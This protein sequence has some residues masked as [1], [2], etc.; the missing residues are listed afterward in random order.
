[1]A[2]TRPATSTRRRTTSDT[3]RACSR[4]ARSS[5]P[6][7]PE[8]TTARTLTSVE[9]VQA[10]LAEQRYLADRALSTAVFLAAELEQPLLLEGE[11]GVGKTEGA[12]ALAGATGS[13]PIRPQCHQ[14]VGLHPPGYD[15]GYG[16]QP[17]APPAARAGARGRR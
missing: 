7:E 6:R 8:D 3:S 16:R 9:S 10:A 5:A 4:G 15:R 12:R 2:P 14:G 17:P 13:R 11:A 1:M